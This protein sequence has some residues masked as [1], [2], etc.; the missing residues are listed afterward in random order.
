VGEVKVG[1]ITSSDSCAAGTREDLSGKALAALCDERGWAVVDYH[2]CADDEE[3]LSVSM[4]EIADSGRANVILTTGGTGLGPRDVTPEA[5]IAVC[6]RLAPG[7]AEHIRSESVKVTGRAILSRGVS[8][9]RGSTLII[10]LP[11]SEKAVR[12]SFAFVAGQL[13]HAVDMMAGGGH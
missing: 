3:S 2:V 11:G 9:L 4:Q 5:T 13:E 7:I 6:D 8:G 1:I 10:N 12:E